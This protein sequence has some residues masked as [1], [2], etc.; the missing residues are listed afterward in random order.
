MPNN[1]FRFKQ[2]TVHQ[3]K[4]AMKVCTDACLFGSLLKTYFNRRGGARVLDIGAGT[5]LLSLMYAQ[6][7]ANALIDAVE[8]DERASKQA[9]ENFEVSPWKERLR[10]H[11][12]SI[13]SFIAGNKY[14]LIVSNP[15]FFENDLKS[16]DDKRN[17]ALHSSALSLEELAGIASALVDD[18]GMFAVLLPYHRA[19]AF[20]ENAAAKKFFSQ[21]RVNVKQSVKHNYFRSILFFTKQQFVASADEISI[22]DGGGQYTKRFAD[23]LKDYYLK[24]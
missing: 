24:L 5:G 20:I 10:I 22:M 13:Q 16:A 12:C 18:N 15:P 19:D 7:N 17:L 8:I 1:F 6:Q 23:L 14:D 11:N 9:K 2:F 4:C 3:E 21:Q